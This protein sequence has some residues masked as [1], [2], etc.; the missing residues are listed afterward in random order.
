MSKEKERLIRM[1]HENKISEEDY[2]LLSAA[3][4]KKSSLAS[5]LFSI[6][7][8]PFQKVAGLY[9]LIIGLVFIVSISYLG[10][11]AEVYFPGILDC[12]NSSVVKNPKAPLNFFL[13]FYQNIISWLVLS[14]LFIIFAKIFQKKNIRIID[15]FGTVALSRFPYVI[16][17]GFLS[18][19]RV[20]NPSFMNIDITK[21]YSLH[22]SIMMSVFGFMVIACMIWQVITYFYALKESSGL[23]GKK[24]W[25]GFIASLLLG[26]VI[27][28]P[29]T[30]LLI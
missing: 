7:I 19:V 5:Q 15:F 9:A 4:D 25:V 28:L 22:P 3:L 23:M 8:N 2:K 24:L 16:L 10:V 29:L 26:E 18:I 11:I 30:T 1:L 6:F 27:A 21:G 20:M 14:I 12:L 17:T 13:L